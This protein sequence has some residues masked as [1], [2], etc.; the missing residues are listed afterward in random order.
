MVFRAASGDHVV[1][2]ALTK[3]DL[4]P[5]VAKFA[6]DTFSQKIGIALAGL[7]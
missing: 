7:G 5:L 6:R 2:R 1:P 4:E 3:G